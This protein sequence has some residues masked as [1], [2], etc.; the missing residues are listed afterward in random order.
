[1]AEIAKAAIAY[2]ATLAETTGMTQT[3]AT[4]PAKDTTMKTIQIRSLEVARIRAR[5]LG[6][7]IRHA[8]Q[9]DG[10]NATIIVLA[11]EHAAALRIAQ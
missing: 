11:D 8:V 9:I 6:S 5:L 4:H 10:D 1:M 3:K 7:G 2:S